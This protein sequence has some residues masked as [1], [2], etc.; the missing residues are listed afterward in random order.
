VKLPRDI[1][2]GDAVKALNSLLNNHAGIFLAP[3][4][5]RLTQIFPWDSR[6]Q[7]SVI[8]GHLRQSAVKNSLRGFFQQAVKRLGFETV[9][10]E[11]SHIRML[12][13][14][15][16]VTIANHKSIAPKTLQ[17]MLRQAAVSLEEFISAL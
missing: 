7:F 11:G 9:R 12:K 16:R 15:R 2:G 4:S 1:S 8:C 3:D 14:T 5:H 13:G 6:L 10:Q 17:S